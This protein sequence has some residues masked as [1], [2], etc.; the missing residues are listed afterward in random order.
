MSE[1]MEADLLKSDSEC[2][3]I[4]AEQLNGG[5]EGEGSGTRTNELSAFR[6]V[7][8]KCKKRR[9]RKAALI[10]RM[11]ESDDPVIVEKQSAI[12]RVLSEDNSSPNL[13]GPPKKPKK[14]Q[15]FKDAVLK[16]LQCVIYNDEHP[17]GEVSAEQ[18]AVISEALTDLMLN[19]DVSNAQ[20]RPHFEY[21]GYS[22]NRCTVSCADEQSKQ[23]L[24]SAVASSLKT[25]ENSK[26]R[27]VLKDDLPKYHKAMLWIPPFFKKNISDTMKLLEIQNSGIKSTN[28]RIYHEGKPQ[29]SGRVFVLGIDEQSLLELHKLNYRPYLG[30]GRANIRL[31]TNAREADS[32]GA[33]N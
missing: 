20:F 13:K 27:V 30:I 25:W 26:L 10:K 1:A 22:H 14:I 7:L 9:L 19:F 18:Y 12:K 29:D 17:S 8:S 4:A 5:T 21:S 24:V 31:T 33:T 32:A 6:P 28:W 16:S 2:E 15:S 3:V 23:W 11:K